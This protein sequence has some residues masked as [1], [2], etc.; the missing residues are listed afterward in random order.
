MLILALSTIATAGTRTK[1]NNIACEGDTELHLIASNIMPNT[2]YNVY[3]DD[4]RATG[5]TTDD[6]GNYGAL[7]VTTI[8]SNTYYKIHWKAKDHEYTTNKKI[9]FQ[10]YGCGW[11]SHQT[12]NSGPSSKGKGLAAVSIVPPPHQPTPIDIRCYD[13]ES[14]WHLLSHSQA[15]QRVWKETCETLPPPKKVKI[16]P[17]EQHNEEG[18]ND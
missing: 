17:C 16:E 4:Y 11:A 7:H 5:L 13:C 12:P 9:I 1:L 2:K 18:I 15:C 14:D 8:P 10:N 3:F 6:K